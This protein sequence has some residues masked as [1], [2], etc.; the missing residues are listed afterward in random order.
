MTRAVSP[1]VTYQI[2]QHFKQNNTEQSASHLLAHALLGAATS[3]ATGNNITTGALSGATSEKAAPILATYLYGKDPK[4]LTQEQKDTI[5]SIISLGT[6]G[7]AY[8]ATDGSVSDAVNAS[9]V[10]KGSVEWNWLFRGLSDN[11]KEYTEKDI[12]DI[13]NDA[14]LLKQKGLEKG[15]DLAPN[16]LDHYIN[17]KGNDL[18]V[19]SDYLLQ[20]S[21]IADADK[22]NQDRFLNHEGGIMKHISD[23]ERRQKYS[24]TEYFDKSIYANMIGESDLYY[25]SGGSTLTSHGSFK[26]EYIN[27]QTIVEG[28][29]KV[30]W[31]DRYDWDDGKVTN[32]MGF[33][34][35]DDKKFAYLEEKGLAHSF[36]MK[37]N[38]QYSFTGTYDNQSKKWRNVK[39]QKKN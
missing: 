11:K 10:G 27:G 12:P 25:G 18:E 5:T 21:S 9:E 38:W 37:S 6:A 30:Y 33:G 29:L 36:D 14:K 35:V 20:F 2:G 32:V 16:A 15:L 31:K 28:I 13:I 34:K 3:Y 1:Q 4:E 39:W 22:Q 19:N 23:I 8:G 26:A 17:G 7:I 24:F